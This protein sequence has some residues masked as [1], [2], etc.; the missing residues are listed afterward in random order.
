MASVPPILWM[1]LG[2]CIWICVV[3][4][5][6]S[7]RLRQPEPVYTMLSECEV[8]VKIPGRRAPRVFRR[9]AP[10][11]EREVWLGDIRRYIIGNPGK[12]L[13]TVEE[14]EGWFEKGTGRTVDAVLGK[15]S[16][17]QL[18]SLRT[19]WLIE[20][21]EREKYLLSLAESPYVSPLDE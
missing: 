8:S 2:A 16:T 18:D 1:M 4:V 9:V 13:V 17:K 7:Y 11:V 3:A 14:L 6:G 20:R 12:M 21:E 10:K 19:L 15:G 5:I